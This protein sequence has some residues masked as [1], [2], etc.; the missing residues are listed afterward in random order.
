VGIESISCD[1]CHFSKS[2]RLPFMSSSSRAN[3]MFE[4][5]HFDIWGPTIESFDGFKY[6]VTLIDDF[7]RVT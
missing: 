2:T 1:T 7:S 4:L 6:Y 3:K 5:V